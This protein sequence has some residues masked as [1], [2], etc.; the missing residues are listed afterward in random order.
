MEDNIPVYNGFYT[1]E[2]NRILHEYIM[3]ASDAE[4][5][6]LIDEACALYAEEN[7]IALKE[8]LNDFSKEIQARDEMK[9]RYD[10]LLKC[11]ED[12]R[13]YSNLLGKYEDVLDIRQ[14]YIYYNETYRK[15]KRRSFNDFMKYYEEYF[16][17]LSDDRSGDKSDFIRR[18]T[19]SEES[20]NGIK[21]PEQPET[22]Y[23]SLEDVP[24]EQKLDHNGSLE[25]LGTENLQYLLYRI[26]ASL[27]Y[28]KKE[29][30]A[31]VLIRFLT[32]KY[33]T[34]D[35]KKTDM[36]AFFS[37]NLLDHTS[38][39]EQ[40]LEHLKDIKHFQKKAEIHLKDIH[41]SELSQDP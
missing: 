26:V 35:H 11:K 5:V 6:D 14:K 41:R 29:E 30:S 32:R 4:L 15:D 9:Q 21:K 8:A 1:E 36:A 23:D 27:G 39:K 37:T 22:Y 18:C 7:R 19:F 25:K 31:S 40:C 38:L 17:K 2:E 10:I 13:I 28:P 3:N 33:S 34:Y 24:V 16:I 12:W 20:K